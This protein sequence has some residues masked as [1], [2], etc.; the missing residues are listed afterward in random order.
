MRRVDLHTTES[1]ALDDAR[2]TRKALDQRHNLVFSQCPRRGE[3][4]LQGR[5]ERH[6]RR[7]HVLGIQPLG[8][9]A[10]GVIELHPE[11]RTVRL[12]RRRP[13]LQERHVAVIFNGHIVR[14][15]Q[16]PAI[17]H[18]VA[19]NQQ[20]NATRRPAPVQPHQR[21]SGVVIGGAQGFT[22]RRLSQTVL[23]ATA[24]GQRQRLLQQVLRT[25]HRAFSGVGQWLLP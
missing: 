4:G 15:T 14:L 18:G 17:D 24:I 20:A 12:A 6:R 8:R 22:H 16:G 5:T 25:V 11:L 3:K 23:Q 7:R 13:A 10:S 1:G 2:R 19:G 9:L 21:L